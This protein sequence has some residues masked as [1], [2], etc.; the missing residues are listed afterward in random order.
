MNVLLALFFSCILPT[1][2]SPPLRVLHLVVPS[3]ILPLLSFTFSRRIS[4]PPPPCD[5]P[6]HPLSVFTSRRTRRFSRVV[7]TVGVRA[8]CAILMDSSP[9]SLLDRAFLTFPL[10]IFKHGEVF[11]GFIIIIIITVVIFL[12]IC[13]QKPVGKQYGTLERSSVVFARAY[14]MGDKKRHRAHRFG[15]CLRGCSRLTKTRGKLFLYIKI[16]S[17]FLKQF[18]T[19][20]LFI[21][22]FIYFRRDLEFPQSWFPIVGDESNSPKHQSVVHSEFAELL[23]RQRP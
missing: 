15:P 19:K 7:F 9:S 12:F 14:R 23:K 11:S 2:T 13:L 1:Q 16:S 8:A 10:K 20:L 21:Y 5:A 6:Y 22:L 18:K 3:F 17:Y 4:I